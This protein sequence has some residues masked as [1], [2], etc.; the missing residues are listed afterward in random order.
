MAF[1]DGMFQDGEPP[2]SLHLELLEASRRLYVAAMK[3]FAP[4]SPGWIRRQP[5]GLVAVGFAAVLATRAECDM[6]AHDLEVR[7]VH[8]GGVHSEAV[9]DEGSP[10]RSPLGM[11]LRICDLTAL[12]MTARYSASGRSGQSIRTDFHDLD[13]DVPRAVGASA[14]QLI[15]ILDRYVLHADRPC[16]RIEGSSVDTDGWLVHHN[17]RPIPSVDTVIKGDEPHDFAVRLGNYLQ[18]K[19]I[20]LGEELDTGLGA[21]EDRIKEREA[22]RKPTD[23]ATPAMT[24]DY[25][26][27]DVADERT[28]AR[29]AHERLHSAHPG[30]VKRLV[31]Y[32]VRR[33][34]RS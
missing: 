22:L 11:G 25:A 17:I 29:K 30:V 4:R 5:A 31:D 8:D 7:P 32:G 16:R 19:Y 34:E 14:R 13:T 23:V 33:T 18:D 15:E 10:G 6:A 2:S 12:E 24:V 26:L 1:H 21:R 27:R 28:R 20:T 3:D 9:D